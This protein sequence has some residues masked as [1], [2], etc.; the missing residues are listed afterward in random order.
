MFADGGEDEE[1]DEAEKGT[2]V[3]ELDDGHVCGEG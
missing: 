1:V 2:D 3:G